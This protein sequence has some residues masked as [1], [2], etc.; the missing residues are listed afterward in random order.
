MFNEVAVKVE[1]ML[2]FYNDNKQPVAKL[3][4]YHTSSEDREETRKAIEGLDVVLAN[5]E[6]AS[7]EVSAKNTTKGLGLQKLCEH[8]GISIDEAIA[9]GDA[10]NDLDVLKRAGL[11]VAMG[12]AN[13]NVKKIADVVVEDCDHDGCVQAIEKYLLL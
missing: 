9:V 7:L 3:N 10:D 8:L 1:N 12:N 5:A 11:S 13:D 6:T 4:L 2:D